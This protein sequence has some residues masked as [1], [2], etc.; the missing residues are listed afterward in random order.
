MKVKIQ[1]WKNAAEYRPGTAD[2]IVWM[3]TIVR[4][5]AFERLKFEKRRIEGAQVQSDL[6][7]FDTIFDEQNTIRNCEIEQQLKGCLEQL[8][9]PP[10]EIHPDGLLLRL[11]SRGNF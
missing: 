5:R 11:Q 10:T 3:V 6:D 7:N 2:P 1:I 9:A 4:Y 8:E